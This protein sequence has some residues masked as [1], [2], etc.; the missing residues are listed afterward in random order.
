MG[1]TADLFLAA[2]DLHR[3]LHLHRPGTPPLAADTSASSVAAAVVL[4][5]LAL[6]LLLAVAISAT[7]H[8]VTT[9][10]PQTISVTTDTP[11]PT[12]VVHMELDPVR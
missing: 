7:S 8:P 6:T 12:V 11:A 2:A 9:Q 4:A 5:L 3:Q 10:R 1:P